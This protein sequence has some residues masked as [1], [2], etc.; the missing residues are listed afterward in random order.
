M[1]FSVRFL[2]MVAG[3]L[4]YQTRSLTEMVERSLP[5]TVIEPFPSL[6]CRVLTGEETVYEE[7]TS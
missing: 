7:V 3:R 4:G 6:T 5:M 1:V 2:T